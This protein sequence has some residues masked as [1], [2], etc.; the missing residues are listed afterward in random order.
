MKTIEVES[1]GLTNA[2]LVRTDNQD[3]FFVVDLARSM[4]VRSSSLPV[5]PGSRLF[6]EQ[7]GQLYLVAD[8]MGGHRAGSE[9]SKLAIE[10]FLGS[11]LNSMRWLAR[12]EPNDDASFADDLKQMLQG[13]HRELQFQSLTQD[14]LQGMGTTLTMAYVAWPKMYIVHAGDT[15]C[16]LLRD[17]MMRLITRDHTVANQMMQAG[18][19]DPN[20][21]ERSPW[22]NVL[23]NALGAGAPDVFAD[24][25]RVDLQAGDSILLCSDGLNKHA[26][27]AT[28]CRIWT[29]NTTPSAICE[30]LLQHAINDGGTDNVT[31]IVSQFRK[32]NAIEPRMQI[33][34]TPPVQEQLIHEFAMQEEDIDTSD[35]EDGN[36][37]SPTLTYPGE[38][39]SLPDTTP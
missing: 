14:A 25:Y 13:A 6:G 33:L 19:L 21:V 22:S 35:G 15:R 24:I 38:K 28:I 1:A 10:Y 3:H 26:D 29:Q 39:R 34:A 2:G 5:A 9:A 36:A 20:S 27:D 8:G 12:I 16:Y 31:V 32:Q 4:F 11:I 7:M 30:Q 18:R 37:T 17:G 23:I